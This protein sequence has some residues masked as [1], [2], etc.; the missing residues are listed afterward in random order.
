MKI[1]S[2]CK[3]RISDELEP[4]CKVA[5]HKRADLTSGSLNSLRDF[6]LDR[7]IINLQ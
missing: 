1:L 2:L 7:L 5:V 6:D 3:K 4:A